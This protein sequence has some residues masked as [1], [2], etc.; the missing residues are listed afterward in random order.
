MKCSRTNYLVS[1]VQVE[2]GHLINVCN[3]S[4]DTF[5]KQIAP[6]D[7]CEISRIFVCLFTI[8]YL[9]TRRMD[10]SEN[11]YSMNYLSR[12]LDYVDRW[13]REE[14]RSCSVDVHVAHNIIPHIG[15][16]MEEI[17]RCEHDALHAW[18][19]IAHAGGRVARQR[20]SVK[21]GKTGETK[22]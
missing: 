9:F 10:F 21:Y 12:T 5:I 11:T 8:L 22:Q 16:R 3:Y 6:V 2:S 18:I 19:Q 4:N 15:G 1:A 20:F 14:V 17:R 7:T 13:L